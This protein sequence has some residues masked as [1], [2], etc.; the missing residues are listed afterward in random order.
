M[1]NKYI[2][3]LAKDAVELYVKKKE[4][5]QPKDIPKELEKEQA[6]FVTITKNKQLRGCIGNIKPL[7]ELYK[8]I[9][10]NAIH[11]ATEDPRFSPVQEDELKDVKYEV[12]ILTIPKELEFKSKEDLF[13]K[14]KN[15][16]VI[17]KKEFNTATFLPQ[18]WEELNNPEEFL[19]NLCMKAELSQDEYLTA[20]ISTYE[21]II[22]K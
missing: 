10:N 13:Q 19:E 1:N 12:S 14:I 15:K 9:I 16:G 20:D 3:K 17:I 21:A 18:V 5:L 11:A 22:I 4:I 2:L 8:A 7:N 6:C